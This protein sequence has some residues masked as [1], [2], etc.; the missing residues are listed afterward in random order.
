VSAPE[1]QVADG[2]RTM[3]EAAVRRDAQLV[4]DLLFS[5]ATPERVVRSVADADPDTV[6][7]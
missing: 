2:L 3:H 4:R 6:S 7:A 1:N 5:L